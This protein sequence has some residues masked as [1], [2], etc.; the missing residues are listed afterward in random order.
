MTDMY[1]ANKT[2]NPA[3]WCYDP[4]GRG[5]PSG[6]YDAGPCM[7]A[8][9]PP[10]ALMSQPHF[11]QADP[12]YLDQIASGLSPQKE[13]HETRYGKWNTQYHIDH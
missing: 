2:K 1:F 7:M 12:F 13:K 9:H 3:N 8:A 5:L 11:Y 10:P 4:N 6:V